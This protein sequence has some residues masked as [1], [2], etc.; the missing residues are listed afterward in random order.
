MLN[1]VMVEFSVVVPVYNEEENVALMH[2]SILRGLGDLDYEVVFVD[3]CSMD[4]TWREIE[5]II[6][7][8]FRGISL[9]KRRGQSFALFIGIK[10]AKGD[11]VAT[12]DGDLQND[13]R[14]IVKLLSKLWGSCGLVCGQ[15]QKRNDNFVR[16]ISSKVGNYVNKKVLGITLKD[17]NCPLKV[18][19]KEC[20]NNVIFFDN[21]HRFIP[22]LVKMQGHR[23]READVRHFPRRY[24]E[25]KYGIHN[26]IFGNLKTM[27]MIKFAPEK[28]I[29]WN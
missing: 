17:N 19:K 20:M 13:P 21:F 10:S 4:G 2:D 29:K 9:S 11:V 8:R 23:V 5:K 26:R 27:F 6:D 3:D 25:A 22:I 24:G 1:K 7:D 16:R 15:R 28:V 18:F 14:D 12:I